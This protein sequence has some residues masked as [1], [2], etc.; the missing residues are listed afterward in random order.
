[1]LQS[2]KKRDKNYRLNRH[3]NTCL[4]MGVLK[5]EVASVGRRT[6]SAPFITAPRWK[7]SSVTSRAPLPLLLNANKREVRCAAELVDFDI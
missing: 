6:S 4:G 2:L 1:M 3:G 5:S 7:P